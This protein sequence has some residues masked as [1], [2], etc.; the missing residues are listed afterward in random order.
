[1]VITRLLRGNLQHIVWIVGAALCLLVVTASSSAVVDTAATASLVVAL[2]V[3][4]F[5][6]ANAFVEIAPRFPAIFGLVVGALGGGLVG[7]FVGNWFPG[8]VAVWLLAGLVIGGLIGGLVWGRDPG[9]R[10]K[11]WRIPERSRPV[12]FLAPAL[13]FLGFTL[14]VPTIR[15]IY[16]GFRGS[17]GEQ[18]LGVSN[19]RS[20][21]DDDD[22]VNFAGF[23]DIP[24]SALFRLG[25]VILV[26]M[27]GIVVVRYL[28]HLVLSRRWASLA[29]APQP[30]QRVM[31][32]GSADVDLS[33]P[34]PVLGLTAVA[35]LV[36]LAML[37]SLT[38]VVWNNVFWVVFVTGFSTIIGLAIAVL[39]DRSR[40][41]SVAKSL[42]FMPMAISFVGASVIWRFVYA[43][44]PGDDQIGIFNAIWVANGGDPESW[45]QQRPWNTL[46]LIAI[47]IWIQTGFAMVVLSSAIKAVP[48]EMLEA[49]RIDG[50][51]EGQT[52]WWVTV[53]QIRSTL[54]V[55]VVTLVITVL[56]VYDIVKVMTNGE[57]GTNV[58]A[59]EMFDEVFRNNN[60]GRGS[61]LA[62]LLFVAV[63]PLMI[64]NVRRLRQGEAR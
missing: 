21:L 41:E 42:I 15:T 23:G 51:S 53:P 52:F 56:K 10:R 40:G 61:A 62:V 22:I 60:A 49:A 34:L 17:D 63:V 2:T 3:G 7:W 4:Y 12:I 11:A 25:M 48:T 54:T 5:V 8:G 24:S 58:I 46:L 59:N 27:L 33:A 16:L 6:E 14:V 19:Y 32:Y 29:R 43:F 37:A 1:V 45:I 39:A 47:M 50:A 35:A 64:A 57:F 20:I 28:L 31:R 44:V 9:A 18:N 55:V 26:V 38:G 30:V 13:L 36:L